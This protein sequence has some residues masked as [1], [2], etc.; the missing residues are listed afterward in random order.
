MF[1]VSRAQS[2]LLSVLFIALF[3]IPSASAILWPTVTSNEVYDCSNPWG[4]G[5]CTMYNMR[6]TA[7]MLEMG[8]ALRPPPPRSGKLPSWHGLHCSR[9]NKKDGYVSCEWIRGS[10]GPI[11]PGACAFRGDSSDADTW[12]LVDTC[13]T[14]ATWQW[15]FHGGAA[16]GGECAVFGIMDGLNLS[17]P[18][19]LLEP[20]TVANGGASFCVKA[21]DPIVPCSVGPLDE[22]DHGPVGPNSVHTV[23]KTAT[24]KCGRRPTL[25]VVGGT[26]VD[27]SAGVSSQLT[28]EMISPTTLRV[29]S[30]LTNRGGVPGRYSSSKILVVSPE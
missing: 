2:Y 21:T 1:Q 3:H 18:W 7:R 19:S 13:Q 28:A 16:P 17:T 14:P 30:R 11:L 20:L 25:Q 23:S 9:G 15:G 5:A 12:T 22:L 10:H 8:P 26:T 27:L 29:E 6:G 24:V 4:Y